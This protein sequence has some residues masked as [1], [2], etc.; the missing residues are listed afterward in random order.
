[1]SVQRRKR[2]DAG[3][4]IPIFKG[5][6]F[7]PSFRPIDVLACIHL[8][9]YRLIW[10]TRLSSGRIMQRYSHHDFLFYI[11]YR[12]I[13][14]IYMPRDAAGVQSV[15][16]WGPQGVRQATVSPETDFID[17]FYRSVEVP[18]VP[19]QEGKVRMDIKLGAYR[20]EWNAELQGC[21]VTFVGDA[22]L[23]APLPTY[24]WNIFSRELPT[25]VGRLR[26][27]MEQFGVAPYTL[28]DQECLVQQTSFYYSQTRKAVFRHHVRKPGTYAIVLD[29]TRM[30]PSGAYGRKQR[31]EGRVMHLLTGS[32]RGRRV[33]ARGDGCGCSCSAVRGGGREDTGQGGT[34]GCG[35][36]VCDCECA[37]IARPA[38]TTSC[39]PR[40]LHRQ[41]VNARDAESEPTS[42][43]EWW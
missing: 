33:C 6:I 31:R 42:L 24:L 16:F 23:R 38:C 9:S 27:S 30:Y 15:R 20:I 28:D 18:E 13:G 4:S 3:T 43:S 7:I 5:R 25:V 21:Y 12:G 17:I 1:M 8:F 41:A 36:G 22:D 40:T 29:R 19:L 34:R 10:D 37:R 2:N 26:G 14:Q 32:S 35:T 11:V 39:P